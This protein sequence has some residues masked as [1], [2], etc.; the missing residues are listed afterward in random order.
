MFILKILVVLMLTLVAWVSIDLALVTGDVML[1]ALGLIAAT[2]S[3]LLL[4]TER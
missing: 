3:F 2:S 4:A 1:S